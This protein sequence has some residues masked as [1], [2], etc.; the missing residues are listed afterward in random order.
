M[1]RGL[2]GTRVKGS[3]VTGGEG[4][5]GT[6]LAG[7]YELR[8]R[9]GR[10]GMAT[11]RRAYQPA[12]DRF[13]AV[14][15]IDPRL[16]SDPTFVER[17]RQEARIAARL[18]HPN[19]LSIYD[20]GDDNGT[21]YLVTELVTGGTLEE[22]L[23]QRGGFAAAL[24]LVEQ[25]GRALDYAHAQG[26]AH[27]DVKPANIF[28]E[29]ERAI[30]ADF[31]IAKQFADTPA[32]GLTA[33]GVGLGT[34][35]YMAPE[36]VLGKPVDGRADLYALGAILYRLVA[37][38]LPFVRYGPEDTA[39]ALV[40]RKIN[41][42]LPPP[43]AFN[44]AISPTLDA[45]LLRALAA[46]PAARYP[47]AAAFVAAARGAL[48]LRAAPTRARTGT[49]DFTVPVPSATRDGAGATAPMPLPP[50]VP[51]ADP[52]M[53]VL[54]AQNTTGRPTRARR[55]APRFLFGGVLALVLLILVASA[56][57]LVLSRGARGEGT[58]T[59]T[60]P[61]L[62]VAGT[63]SVAATA[64]NTPGIP[65]GTSA[66][67]VIAST[68]TPT[69]APTTTRATPNTPI[70]AVA[71]P[72]TATPAPTLTPS[73]TASPSPTISPSPTV[74]PSPTTS[75][76]P[77]ATPAPTAS[78]APTATP[79]PTV[80]AATGNVPVEVRAAILSLPG[81]SSG[82]FIDLANS[83]NNAS[84]D[85]DRVF[86]AASLIKLSIAGATYQRAANG[87][88]RLSDR[89]VL[90]ES[91]KVGGTGILQ[92]QPAGTA[93][94]IDQLIAIMLIN[95]DNTAANLIVDRI[96]GFGTVNAF[97][98]AQGMGNTIMRRK[99]NDL[100]AQA[101]GLDNTTT[102]GDIARFFTQLQ[103]GQ[104]VDRETSD[105]LRTILAQRGREDKDWA[106]LNL[107]ADTV[108][109]HMTGTETGL[110]GDAILVT[111]GERQYILVLF[112]SAPDEAGMEA[113]IARVS[114]TIYGLA[115]AR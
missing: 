16:A 76:P 33:S 60:P 5:A 99:L 70:V 105:R 48:G 41:E 1:R 64:T 95:S 71:T 62:A 55:S 93:Y 104:I 69:I 19:I 61:L 100:A 73:P 67:V 58:A 20:F 78:P 101:R 85:P 27:R 49:R 68:N 57:A 77:T 15:L 30:L 34:P 102:S 84:D 80:A 44:A 88:V 22:R 87:G 51:N 39:L 72:P 109:Q 74:S 14:K 114:A 45:I 18:R 53:N 50:G 110:R 31:G 82:V 3:C 91:D 4:T 46:D 35:E 29:E 38:R 63:A 98:A 103:A 9:L 17:F 111:V 10:G 47:T 6:L 40:M 43:S 59:A 37:G 21:L 96:G 24:E 56:G 7:R 97:S 86:S 52:T 112:V 12:L 83:A 25:V 42:P 54:P 75:P 2:F 90:Q 65:T 28:L 107:P 81:T 26:I 115:T 108:A 113:A 13:V 23:D 89:A 36:Q 11:V 66:P 106:L 32:A 79:S 92:T 94:T 8:E